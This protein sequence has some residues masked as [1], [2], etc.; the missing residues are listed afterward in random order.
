MGSQFSD[1][2]SS[3][4][5]KKK[6]LVPVNVVSGGLLWKEM[7][8]STT[9]TIFPECK[10]VPPHLQFDI[11]DWTFDFWLSFR[12]NTIILKSVDWF[13]KIARFIHLQKALMKVF[14]PYKKACPRRGDILWYT[15]YMIHY[16]TGQR[17][18]YQQLMCQIAQVVRSIC[19][20][21]HGLKS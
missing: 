2:L 17:C 4:S 6:F 16:V 8:P 14:A 9:W 18:G 19:E 7:W 3:R 10:P 11:F 20:Y 13:S 12:H 15:Y 1:F 21:I 5:A